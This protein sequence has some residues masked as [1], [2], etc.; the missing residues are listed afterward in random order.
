MAERA[1]SE[2][3]AQY[4]EGYLRTPEATPEDI[5]LHESMQTILVEILKEDPWPEN[6]KPPESK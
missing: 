1:E 5:A 6:Q 2:L 4:V 3:E